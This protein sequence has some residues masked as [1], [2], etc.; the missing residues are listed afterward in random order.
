VVAT[1]WI[2]F[3]Y[4]PLIPIGSYRVVRSAGDRRNLQVIAKEKIQRNQVLDGGKPAGV[5]A[6]LYIG[7]IF[8]I[9]QLERLGK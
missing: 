6:L 8:V 5:I 1:R 4:M 7:V 2:E 9:A 3:A